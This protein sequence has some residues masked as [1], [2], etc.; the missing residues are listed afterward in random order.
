MRDDPLYFRATRTLFFQLGHDP[1]T[2][3]PLSRPVLLIATPQVSQ[4]A[5]DQ[6]AYEGA[7]IR[8]VENITRIKGV[9]EN[10]RWR[11][12][13][14]K[15]RIWELEEYDKVLLL[16]SDQM[17]GKPIHE[18]WN[19]AAR[20]NLTAGGL[21]AVSDNRGANYKIPSSTRGYLNGWGPSPG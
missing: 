10:N 5:L 4:S 18:I 7:D 17:L 15:R 20:V 3:D 14:T 11:G 8:V 16:G 19:D 2:R 6:L 21:A 1:A 13:Y 9:G 12:L